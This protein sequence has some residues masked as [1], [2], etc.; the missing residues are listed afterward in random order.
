MR[1]QQGA[2]DGLLKEL[3]E[4][5]AKEGRPLS[6]IPISEYKKDASVDKDASARASLRRAFRY[7]TQYAAPT[8]RSRHAQSMLG[9]ANF[10]QVHE[11]MRSVDSW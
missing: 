3:K 9:F 7:E 5:C 6:G 2:V 11:V 8:R 4:R 10:K 1:L